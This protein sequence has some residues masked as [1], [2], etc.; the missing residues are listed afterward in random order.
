METG[1]PKRQHVFFF[2]F[3]FALSSE[4]ETRR[5]VRKWES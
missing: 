4:I 1:T 2:V 3:F 5:Y